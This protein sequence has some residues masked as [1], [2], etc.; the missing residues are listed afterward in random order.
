MAITFVMPL[1]INSHSN[2]NELS[3]VI[4][5][6][7]KSLKKYLDLSILKDFMII[8]PH[9]ELEMIRKKLLDH[10]PEFPFVF[11]DEDSLISP[12]FFCESGWLKQ[13]LL[14]LLIANRV[15]TPYYLTLDSD[16]FLTKP[17]I[18]TSLFY[19]GKL[20]FSRNPVDCHQEWWTASSKILNFNYRE[21]L[22]QKSLMGVTP[23][24]LVTDVC[25]QLQE[26]LRRVS[27]TEYTLY[28]VFLIS[29]NKVKEY[30]SFEGP[31]LIGNAIW[32]LEMIDSEENGLPELVEKIFKNNKNSYFSLIQSNISGLDQAHLAHLIVRQLEQA[33]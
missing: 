23:E 5:I 2:Y 12:A 21:I 31:H 33:Q 9:T 24:I 22:K 7:M 13:M 29:Q 11:V 14:K 8:T 32:T 6:Q 1:K 30:Y 16:V 10:Y 26:N 27:N 18:E 19:E 25:L 3:R 15:T 4:D 17:F 28:W 20:I